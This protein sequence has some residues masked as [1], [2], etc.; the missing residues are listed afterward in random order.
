MFVKDGHVTV[1]RGF[2]FVIT[3]IMMGACTAP[4]VTFEDSGEFITCGYTLSIPHPSGYPLFILLG[5]I[6]STMPFGEIG[7]RVNIMSAFFSALC[8]EIMTLISAKTLLRM[9]APKIWQDTARI[10]TG[11]FLLSSG[12]I[13]SQS[14]LSEVYALHGFFVSLLMYSLIEGY[15]GSVKHYVLAF[16]LLGI[17]LGNH[18]TLIFI[19]PLLFILFIRNAFS[20]KDP[21]LF[22]H[23]FIGIAL[24]CIGISIYFVLMVRARGNPPLN[25]GNP[26]DIS[27]LI[28]VIRQKEF[29][30]IK[31]ITTL[32][33]IVVKAG[34]F[35]Q[36]LKQSYGWLGYILIVLSIGIIASPVEA[37]IGLY[38]F[39]VYFVA[40]VIL[41]NVE[42]VILYSIRVFFMP[43]HIALGFLAGT[44]LVAVGY[45]A[46]CKKKDYIILLYIT[47]SVSIFM[48]G[49]YRINTSARENDLRDY[50]Y[51]YDWGMNILKSVEHKSVIF[52]RIDNDAF[53]LYYMNNVLRIKNDII[54]LNTTFL[55]RDWYRNEINKHYPEAR[56]IPGGQFTVVEMMQGIIKRS[57]EYAKRE[58]TGVYLIN[59]PEKYY[60]DIPVTAEG[61]VS[62]TLDTNPLHRAI[63]QKNFDIVHRGLPA[64]I[65]T[66]DREIR[67]KIPG[68]IDGFRSLGTVFADNMMF[69]KSIQYYLESLAFDQ[70]SSGTFRSIG[71]MFMNR[72]LWEL[73]LASFQKSLYLGDSS[74]STY[75]N[76]GYIYGKMEQFDKEKD[77]YYKSI[78]LFPDYSKS[79]INLG[80][81]YIKRGD[82]KTAK[83]VW[84]AGL[85]NSPL[86]PTLKKYLDLM[87]KRQS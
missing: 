81:W 23:T 58:K 57:I 18:L 40:P 72:G 13:W 17:G 79:Y 77:A 66:L 26:A 33:D 14:V 62:R 52:T 78:Q 60:Q 85:K 15:Y 6:F 69:D 80:V 35:I 53:P 5:K 25:W 7:W 20:K 22:L 43:S 61:I 27:H 65:D 47:I 10:M 30:E 19:V 1:P 48:F 59:I 9:T 3:L 64:Q 38:V 87:K 55:E 54:H 70:N 41:Y 84:E 44:G 63:L 12:L 46:S 67:R 32:N 28:D 76:L 51:A 36:Y 24:F 42:P 8:I 34:L 74:P 37:T 75:L 4:S 82:S 45:A 71:L 50:Y 11:T 16:F 2:F 56:L 39:C 83:S 31:Q 29:S 86:D 49:L 68:Y 73:A 21:H